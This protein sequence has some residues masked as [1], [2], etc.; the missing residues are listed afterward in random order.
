[1]YVHKCI[2]TCIHVCMEARGTLQVGWAGWLVR[3]RDSAVF[4]YLTNPGLLKF[5]V[6]GSN[7]Y[8]H[9]LKAGA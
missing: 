6:W 2:C 1:M 7:S 3:L 5:R 9:A 4:M 8:S